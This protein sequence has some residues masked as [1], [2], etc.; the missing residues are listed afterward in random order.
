MVSKPKRKRVIDLVIGLLVAV[1]L[2][3]LPLL[4]LP[5]HITVTFN[6][7]IGFLVPMCFYVILFYINYLYL[8]KHLLFN[9][10]WGYFILV[11][12]L[13]VIL[14]SLIL[15]YWNDFYFE[16]VLKVVKVEP[17]PHGRKTG[18]MGPLIRDS[19]FMFLTV[20][21]SVA[22]K[23]TIE[24]YRTEQE[25]AKVE[26]VVSEA[27]LKSLK[28]QLNPHFLFNTLNNI[29]ALMS[30]DQEKAQDA[31]LGLS[32][33][34]RYVLYGDNE[35]KVPLEKELAF[36]LNYIRIMSLR[37]TENVKLDVDIDDYHGSLDIAP[38]IFISLV[39]NAFKH[40][41]SQ[42]SASNILISIKV[43]KNCVNCIVKNT[44]FPKKENDMSGSGIG[45]E[46][47][48]RRLALIYPD[49]FRYKAGKENDIYC[50]ELSLTL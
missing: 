36:T 19:I 29:Y 21:L 38:L 4:T 48:K 25:R 1:I 10:K 8:I 5:R 39:E 42:D 18:F 43:V 7:Y 6:T 32:K 31:I 35:K 37:L 20:S 41:V 9:R 47:L 12:L 24:W 27:E 16:S 45:I 50:A 30:I 46:N 2:F 33:I 3:S 23:M 14:F 34:L 17:G 22:L 28:N 15:H 13:I 44:Y 26:A 11:N 40:G 49:K